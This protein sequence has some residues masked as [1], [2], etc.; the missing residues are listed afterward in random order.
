MAMKSPKQQCAD[1]NR[2]RR[3]EADV[4]ADHPNDGDETSKGHAQDR[5]DETAEVAG[6]DDPLMQEEQGVRAMKIPR[7][8]CADD[9]RTRRGEADVKREL[10]D[11]GDETSKGH[12]EDR[13]NETAE[14]AGV[15]D[16]LM[17]EEQGVRAMKIPRQQCADDNRT[18]RGEADIKRELPN[19]GDET[20]KGH[21]EDRDNETAEVAGVD[22]P[23]LQERQGVNR[24]RCRSGRTCGPPSRSGPRR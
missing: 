10:P 22:G 3:D 11:E 21:A 19:E 4:E 9:N 23:L 12:A 8:Q 2:T 13:D 16:P 5:D 24:R 20:S 17:Q 1:D 7:Q 15:D 14:V 6:V 18:R